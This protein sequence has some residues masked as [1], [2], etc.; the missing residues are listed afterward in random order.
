MRNRAGFVRQADETMLKNSSMIR[1]WSST[2]CEWALVLAA[3]TAGCERGSPTP[4]QTELQRVKAGNLEV[5]LLSSRDALRHGKDAFVIEFLSTPAGTRVDVG[6]VRAVANMPM[7]GTP[8]FG[9]ID[10]TRTSV[11]GRYAADSDLGMAG[12]WRLTIDWDGPAGRGSVTSSETV[13]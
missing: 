5:V 6:T 7:A 10:I 9:S 1:G 2:V 11:P 12:T 13:R 8:M 3:A 4:A